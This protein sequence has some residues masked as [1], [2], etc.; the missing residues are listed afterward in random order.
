MWINVDRRWAGNGNENVAF[1]GWD[2]G[3]SVIVGN[4]VN[5]DD[6]FNQ[7]DTDVW[8]LLTIPLSD[9]GLTGQTIDAFRMQFTNQANTAPE[10]FIDDFDIQESGP[11]IPFMVGPSANQVYQMF[12][13]DFSFAD[14]LDTTLN[15]NSMHN[16]AYNQI[17]GV[18]KLDSGILI[19]R[20]IDEETVFSA[21]VTSLF[22]FMKISGEIRSVISDGTNTAL[23]VNV[24]FSEPLELRGSQLD[25]V[26]V[27][28]ADDLSGLLE[29]NAF[30]RGRSRMLE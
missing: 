17:L 3:G 15:D 8:Q 9:M 2:T 25:K 13:I 23:T 5:L 4:E 22:D 26:S 16:L 6:Y 7:G 20:I 18:P 21:S 10:F 30:A 27:Q 1:F 11:P 19:S 28:V 24:T 12:G 29:F 14:A